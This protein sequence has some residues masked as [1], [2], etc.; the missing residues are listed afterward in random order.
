MK[1]SK[2]AYE[3]HL[4]MREVSLRPGAE[5][6]PRWASWTLIHVTEGAG[7]CLQPEL[8][9]ELETGAVLLI[10]GDMRGVVRASNLSALTLHLYSVMP[11]RLTGLLTLSEQSFFQ[12]AA[13]RKD[14][15]ILGPQHPIALQMK[16]L[17]AQGNK[18][19]LLFRVKLFHLFVEV[20][21]KELEQPPAPGADCRARERLR[22]FLDETPSSELLEM[23]FNEIAQMTQCTSRHLSRIFRELVGKSFRDK[24]AEIRLARARELLATSNSKVVDV[25]LESGY[26]SLSLF[27]LMFSR[28]FGTSP[29]KWREKRGRRPGAGKLEQKSITEA[30]TFLPMV[31]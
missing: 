27:N 12:A 10:T 24:R 31:K 3:P 30:A 26:K 11:A 7:Y 29:G 23:S 18:A 17:C 28:R 4:T 2:P 5:W 13:S 6:A 16:E 9:R 15:R 20:F 14:L 19:G 25:A 21:N 8:N 1:K 22:A